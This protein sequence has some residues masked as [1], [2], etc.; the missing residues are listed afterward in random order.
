MKTLLNDWENVLAN[1]RNELVFESRNKNY[2]AF[3][4]RQENHRQLF[5]ALFCSASF[6]ILLAFSPKIVNL[7]LAE[8]ECAH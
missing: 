3:A 4:L 8:T 5:F 2:G 1:G 6:F 7:P